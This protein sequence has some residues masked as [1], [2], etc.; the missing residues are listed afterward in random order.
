MTMELFPLYSMQMRTW[1]MP[2]TGTTLVERKSVPQFEAIDRMVL[3][4]G[5]NSYQRSH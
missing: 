4:L 2:T 5:R 3:T 1:Q